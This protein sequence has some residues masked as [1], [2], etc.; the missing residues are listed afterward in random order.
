MSLLFKTEKFEEKLTKKRKKEIECWRKYNFKSRFF[1]FVKSDFTKFF[2]D[3]R[4]LF[5]SFFFLRNSLS[6]Q[7]K[8]QNLLAVLLSSIVI[9]TDDEDSFW[10]SCENFANFSQKHVPIVPW[11]AIKRYCTTLN[12]SHKIDP[13][14]SIDDFKEKIYTTKYL[15]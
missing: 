14:G 8:I 4:A 12:Q 1:F 11:W 13:H 7:C 3:L 6:L 9:T 5:K 2:A 10:F 15:L